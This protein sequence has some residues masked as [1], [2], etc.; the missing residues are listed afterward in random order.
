MRRTRRRWICRGR[1]GTGCPALS[2]KGTA[3]LVDQ[4]GERAGF[5]DQLDLTLSLAHGV[6][7][8]P[9]AAAAEYGITAAKEA[10]LDKEIKDYAVVMA[11]PQA[12]IADRKSLTEQMRAK[13]NAVEGKFDSLDNLVLQFNGTAAGR[14]LIA[15]YQAARIVRDLGAGPKPPKPPGP[16]T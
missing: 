6:T 11:T 10:V 8:G 3:A 15:A 5:K 13:F 2:G 9:Q 14:A 12:S 4:E 16:T 7:T 1:S